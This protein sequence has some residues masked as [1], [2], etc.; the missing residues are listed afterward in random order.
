MSL[1]YQERHAKL[2]PQQYLCQ[3]LK[4]KDTRFEQCSPYVFASAAYLEEKQMDR[5]IG[6]S[7]RKGKLDV[8]KDGSKVSFILPLDLAKASDY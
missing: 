7:F 8:T 6:V 3:R 4:N 2:T 5:N 1:S